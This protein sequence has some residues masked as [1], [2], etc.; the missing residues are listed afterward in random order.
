MREFDYNGLLL[1][2]YQGKLFEKSVELNC[3]TGIFM[4]RFLHSNLLEKM[5]MNETAFLSLDV[6]EGIDSILEQ[7]SVK[8]L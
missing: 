5:D 8:N 4:R 1:A 7:G 6:Q 2:E 3:S